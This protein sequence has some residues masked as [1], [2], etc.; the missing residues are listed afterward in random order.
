MNRLDDWMERIAEEA[1]E[2]PEQGGGAS[3]CLKSH[4]YSRLI[5][6]AEEEGP[7]AGLVESK[8]SGFGLCVFEEI[9]R[10]TPTPEAAQQYQY[11]KICHAR[12][13]GEK[14][15]NAPIFWPNCPYS[16]FQR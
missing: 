4:L 12:V 2:L 10:I 14:M 15:E 6:L 16:E 1:P 3:T 8:Q 13:L 9:V 7:L 11:C 5:G